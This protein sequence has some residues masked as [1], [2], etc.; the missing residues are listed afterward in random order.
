MQSRYQMSKQIESIFTSKLSL[1]Y[2]LVDTNN[3]AIDDIMMKA[4]TNPTRENFLNAV[5]F[6]NMATVLLYSHDDKAYAHT[7]CDVPDGYLWLIQKGY[8]DI[9][10]TV[11]KTQ[12][13]LLK[14]FKRGKKTGS[15]A[16]D[17]DT[18]KNL[19]KCAEMYKELAEIMP[20][21]V[22]QTA[23]E[24]LKDMSVG[25]TSMPFLKLGNDYGREVETAGGLGK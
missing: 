18:M 10:A 24:T 2:D 6:V 12:D 4:R 11:N 7:G 16:L 22:L 13:G 1:T 19:L 15:Y 5:D 23:L 20:I 17:G 8:Q 14:T 3:E 9:S 21:R 25:G